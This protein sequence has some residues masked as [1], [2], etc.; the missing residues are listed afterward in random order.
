MECDNS[1]YL[2]SFIYCLNDENVRTSILKKSLGA[3]KE[4]QWLG[5]WYVRN[6]NENRTGKKV[7]L[8]ISKPCSFEKKLDKR[9]LECIR[10]KKKLF[11]EGSRYKAFTVCIFYE[12]NSVHFVSFCFDRKKKELV[13]FDPG[14]ELYLHGMKTIVPQIRNH[15]YDAGLIPSRFLSQDRFTLGRC[16]NFKFRGKKYG[17][18]FNGKNIDFPA[19]AFCQTWTL[20]FIQRLTETGNHGFLV[21][22]CGKK[23]RHRVGFLMESFILP[24][25]RNNRYVQKKYFQEFAQ[26]ASQILYCLK[27][28][29]TELKAS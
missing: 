19:D 16:Q 26:D 1:N 22:W 13:S 15:F 2:Q 8:V 25:L 9:L 12:L 14:V 28:H 10:D 6:Q 7:E 20:F 18:Q 4:Y 17:V 21:E 24:N 29:A 11:L 23:P 3:N 27:G 5:T